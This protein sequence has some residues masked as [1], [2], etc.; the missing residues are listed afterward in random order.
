M[1]QHAIRLP[2]VDQSK[3]AQEPQAPKTDYTTP[4]MFAVGQTVELIQGFGGGPYRDRRT[5]FYYNI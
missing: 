2:V 5:G 1:L 4:Q 3:P